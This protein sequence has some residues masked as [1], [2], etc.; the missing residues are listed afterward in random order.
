ML[1]GRKNKCDG[2]RRVLGKLNTELLLTISCNTITGEHLVK[3]EGE[4]FKSKHSF[5]KNIVN[6]C[7]FLPWSV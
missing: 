2:I 3:Q 4:W 5:T 6:S 1:K 7:I